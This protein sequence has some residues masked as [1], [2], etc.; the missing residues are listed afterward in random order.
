MLFLAWTIGTPHI[1]ST[2]MRQRRIKI[3][4]LPMCRGHEIMI[5]KD[6]PQEE[7]KNRDALADDVTK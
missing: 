3:E 5:G 2:D 6:L 4:W 1:L 7:E